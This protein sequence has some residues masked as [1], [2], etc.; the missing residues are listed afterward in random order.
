MILNT[1]QAL[2]VGYFTHRSPEQVKP[3]SRGDGL[4]EDIKGVDELTPGTIR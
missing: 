1:P 3:L 2:G 4:V